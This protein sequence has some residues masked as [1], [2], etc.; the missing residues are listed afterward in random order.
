MISIFLSMKFD[1]IKLN[2]YNKLVVTFQKVKSKGTERLTFS[3]KDDAQCS[4]DSRKKDAGGK[5]PVLFQIYN[6]CPGVE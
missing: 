5:D 6:L 2:I 3:C 1:T 4:R